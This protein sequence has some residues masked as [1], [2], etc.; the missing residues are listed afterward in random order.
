MNIPDLNEGDLVYLYSQGK[1]INTSNYIG[2]FLKQGTSNNEI[3]L[4]NVLVAE[5]ISEWGGAKV[6]VEIRIVSG[7]KSFDLDHSTINHIIVGKKDTITEL[8]R[9]NLDCLIPLIKK[10]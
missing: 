2:T 9:A 5:T 4:N 8:K 1:D 3:F 7:S 6:P 10:F